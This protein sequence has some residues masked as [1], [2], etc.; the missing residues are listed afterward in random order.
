MRDR[1][2]EVNIQIQAIDQSSPGHKQ[3]MGKQRRTFVAKTAVSVESS[4]DPTEHV[5]EES[6]VH[7]TTI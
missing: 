3:Q 1:T 6:S 7:T 2:A 5:N 4:L